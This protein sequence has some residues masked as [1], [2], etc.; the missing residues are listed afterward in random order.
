MRMDYALY[1]LAVILFV[2][3]AVF[4]ILIKAEDGQL[5]YVTSTAVLGVLSIGAGLAQRPKPTAAAHTQDAASLVPVTTPESTPVIAAP[6]GEALAVPEVTTPA[7][8]IPA[9]IPATETGSPA[10]LP[11]PTPVIPV[12]TAPASEVALAVKSDFSQIRG[13][14]EARVTQ[15]KTNGINS[16]Q[17]LANASAEDL[18]VKLGVSPKIVKMW[19]GSARKQSK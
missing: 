3:S 11:T 6:P 19:I 4:F 18:A 13:I 14:N 1:G 17:D 16:I 2:L 7:E 12:E 15:L 8:P 9:L 10:P 5:I